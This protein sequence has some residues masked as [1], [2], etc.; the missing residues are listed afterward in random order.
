MRQV[1]FWLGWMIINMTLILSCYLK[2]VRTMVR[3][4]FLVKDGVLCWCSPVGTA[5]IA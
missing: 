5:A 3:W 1:I 2:V 4:V